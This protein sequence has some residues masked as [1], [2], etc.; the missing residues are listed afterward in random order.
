ME[1]DHRQPTAWL[2]PRDRRLEAR[3][4]VG[5]LAVDED[6][7]RLEAARGGMDLVLAARHHRRDHLGQLRGARDRF[8]RAR[9]DDGAGDA[10]RLPLLARSEEQPS[11]LQSLMRISY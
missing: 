10:P 3:L 5:Q 4:Q 1:A 9:G 7:D 8:L 2:E 6:A 11:E